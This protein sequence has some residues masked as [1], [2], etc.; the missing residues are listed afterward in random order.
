MFKLLKDPICDGIVPLTDYLRIQNIIIIIPLLP[1]KLFRLSTRLDNAPNLLK[2]VGK[3]P[4]NYDLR[5]I[6]LMQPSKYP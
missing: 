2:D 4:I 6:T 1:F 3:V 5:V